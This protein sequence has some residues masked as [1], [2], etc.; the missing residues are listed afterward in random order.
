MNL[1]PILHERT[2]LW[3]VEILIVHFCHRNT[4]HGEGERGLGGEYKIQIEDE[5]KRED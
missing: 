4:S 2:G 5:Q 3:V 1:K